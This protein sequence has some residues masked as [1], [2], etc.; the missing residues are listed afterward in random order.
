MLLLI[1]VFLTTSFPSFFARLYVK[2]SS[3]VFDEFKISFK[4]TFLKLTVCFFLPVRSFFL[5]L[6]KST[7]LLYIA[8]GDNL[9]FL[10]S[11]SLLFFFFLFS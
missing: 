9:T 1:D 7:I 10:S 5:S 6:T 2:F 11:F 4:L 8:L 3:F